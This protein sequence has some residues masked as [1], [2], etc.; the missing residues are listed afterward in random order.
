MISDTLYEAV[1]EID[2]YLSDEAFN[3]SGATRA[4][5][6]AVRHEMFRLRVHLDVVPAE[7]SRHGCSCW[8]DPE[9]AARGLYCR[10]CE[11]AIAKSLPAPWRT[12]TAPLAAHHTTTEGEN[13]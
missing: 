9:L 12:N 5:I 6:E 7:Y 8:N 11:T 3:Y 2:R 13:R 1:E 10:E 4:R